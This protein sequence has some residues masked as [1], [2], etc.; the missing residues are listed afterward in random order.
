MSDPPRPQIPK[1]SELH[2]VIRTQR[3]ELRPIVEADADAIWPVVSRP[4]FP[5]QMSWEAHRDIEQTREFVRRQIAAVAENAGVVWAIVH[6][7]SVA[8]CIGFDGSR[9]QL[10]A[11]RLD[12]AELGYWLAP[13]YWN[14]GITT[15]AASSVVRFGFDTIGLHKITVRCFAENHASRR[16]IEKVGFRY[17]GRAEEDIWRD[18]RWHA[19]LLFELTAGEWGQGSRV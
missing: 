18:G 10:R 15:E 17:V 1:L 3:L 4:D 14:K 8:G 2:L 12:R 16:V 9:W 19:H 6:E 11:L 5:R 7:G 13:E